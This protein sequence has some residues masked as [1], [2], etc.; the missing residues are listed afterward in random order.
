MNLQAMGDSIIAAQAALDTL[1][2][3]PPNQYLICPIPLAPPT[4]LS[5]PCCVSP[6]L[7]SD[8]SPL[9]L[10]I[11][12]LSPALFKFTIFFIL[13]LSDTEDYPSL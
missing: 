6:F 1:A 8:S 3:F 12:S 2:A 7:F 4:S 10:H 11:P 13:N 5:S 9:P